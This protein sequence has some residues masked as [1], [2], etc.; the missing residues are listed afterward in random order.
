VGRRKELAGGADEFSYG[1]PFTAEL[2]GIPGLH[3]LT[4]LQHGTA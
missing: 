4:P 2:K 3:D 1:E